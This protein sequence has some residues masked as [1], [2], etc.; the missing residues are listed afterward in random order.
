MLCYNKH[1]DINSLN[2]FIIISLADINIKKLSS[3][4]ANKIGFYYLNGEEM[5]DY[6]LEDKQ[7]MIDVCGI[8]YVEEQT[9]KVIHSL[10]DYEKSVISI[11]YENFSKYLRYL[12]RSKFKVIYLN[13]EREDLDKEYD[14][15]LKT[16]SKQ[17]RQETKKKFLI[18]KIGLALMVFEERDNFVRKNSDFEVKYDISNIDK[19]TNKMMSFLI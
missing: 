3:L 13:I 14:K 2:N 11:N 1:M 16:I 9:K 19:T 10:N 7:K 18:S 6:S 4:F 12:D 15:L 17:K 5:I 8:D